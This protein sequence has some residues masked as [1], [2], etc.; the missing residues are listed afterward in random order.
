MPATRTVVAALAALVAVCLLGGIRGLHDAR[1]RAA[2]LAER[3]TSPSSAIAPEQIRPS[4]AEQAP[5]AGP[6]RAGGG[7]SRP[8]PTWIDH[9]TAPADRRTTFA[10]DP[11]RAAQLVFSDEFNLDGRDFK[12][13]SD[14]KWTA[15]HKDDYTNAALHF[16]NENM[17]STN[18]GHLN[19]T[20]LRQDSSWTYLDDKT[21]KLK[22]VRCPRTRHASA[23]HLHL[24]L[25]RSKSFTSPAWSRDGISFASPAASWK[26]GRSCRARPRRAGCGRR[27]G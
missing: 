15:I 9:D 25:S 19:L 11:D 21:Q 16:Y 14:P 12:D 20:T 18:G 24:S 2:V 6:A 10:D 4:P 5:G 26:Y 27:S 17:A 7:E 8:A 1:L 13:G 3:S 22:K 23:A